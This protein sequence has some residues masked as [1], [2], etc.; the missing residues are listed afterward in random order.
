MSDTPPQLRL[1]VFDWAGTA[2]DFGSFAPVAAFVAVFEA[3]G[4]AASVA[5]ARKPMGMHKKDHLVAMLHD[6][7]IRQRWREIHGRDWNAE[8]V[9]G[10]YRDLVPRQ[11]ATVEQHADLVPGLLECADELRAMGLKLGGTTG[12]FREAAERCLEAARRQGYAP[13]VN[14][15]GDDVPAGRPAPWM[16]YRAMENLG[17]YPP[18]AVLKLGDTR[19]DIDEGRNAGCWSAAVTS[20]SS[21]MGMD[22]AAY[23]ALS[24]E[25]KAWRLAEVERRFLDW[26]AHAVVESLHEVPR[27]VAQVNE[28]LARGE[29]PC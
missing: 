28:R 6:A 15:C 10:M 14:V 25:E 21:E 19:A 29:R 17:V 24:P 20:S 13:D 23:A 22:V 12:Y 2:I 4:V 7:G 26:G 9:E 8:D 11:L 1:V 5:E 18:A 16:V 3:R 27:L